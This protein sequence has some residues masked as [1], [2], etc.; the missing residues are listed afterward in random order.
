MGWSA[1]ALTA[2]LIKSLKG[3]SKDLRRFDLASAA[4][5]DAQ[6]D[7]IRYGNAEIVDE[8]VERLQLGGIVPTHDTVAAQE[9]P[10]WGQL[11]VLEQ[12]RDRAFRFARALQM[13]QAISDHL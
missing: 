13:Q 3:L 5:I 4:W 12:L 10:R 7:E 2:E 1:G 8:L 11:R 9:I 6:G